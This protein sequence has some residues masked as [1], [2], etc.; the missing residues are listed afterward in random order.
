MPGRY[1]GPFPWLGWKQLFFPVLFAVLIGISVGVLTSAGHSAQEPTPTNVKPIPIIFVF[2]AANGTVTHT[3]TN[4]T[5]TLRGVG[6]TSLTYGGPS[7]VSLLEATVQST[8]YIVQHWQTYQFASKPPYAAIVPSIPASNGES[9]AIGIVVTS[10]NYDVATQVLQVIGTLSGGASAIATLPPGFSNANLYVDTV[11]GKTVGGCLFQPGVNCAGVGGDA[12]V[13][14]NLAFAQLS[15]SNFS[16]ANLTGAN[17]AEANFAG[18][19]LANASLND[20]NLTNANLSFASL[21]QANLTDAILADATL[22]S[23]GAQAA[24][25]RGANMTGVNIQATN[26]ANAD[27]SGADLSGAVGR[28]TDLAGAHLTNANLTNVNLSDSDLSGANF[29]NANLT[30]ADFYRSSTNGAIFNGAFFCN[31]TMPDGTVE[32]P[33]C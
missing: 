14:Q 23:A 16:A 12:F 13:G 3:G 1:I 21:G 11:N 22:Y 26:L 33:G 10:L 6:N 29:T 2:N 9:T 4:L 24:I 7:S 25:L 27:L 30:N 32:N 15:G 19:K 20:T 17:L 8:A 5:V 31:T 18:A 28:S